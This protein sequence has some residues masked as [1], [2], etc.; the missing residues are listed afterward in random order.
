MWWEGPPF[1]K[2]CK[3]EWPKQLDSKSDDIALSELLKTSPQ[4]THVLSTVTENTIVDLDDFIDVQ[5]FSNFNFFPQ[6]SFHA[7]NYVFPESIPPRSSRNNELPG[8]A[9]VKYWNTSFE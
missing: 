3:E 6:T 4:E 2:S 1:L 7:L 9:L 8:S 5:K